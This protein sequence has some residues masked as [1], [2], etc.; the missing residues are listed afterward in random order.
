MEDT[1]ET[2]RYRA[3]TD[4]ERQ[5][6]FAAD[7]DLKARDGWVPVSQATE[8][9][10]GK[11]GLELVVTYERPIASGAGD[12]PAVPLAAGTSPV[13]SS[14]SR[15][16]RLDSVP[17]G[18]PTALVS[19]E[20]SPSPRFAQLASDGPAAPSGEHSR[21]RAG[22]RG[23]IRAVLGPSR[24]E[25][26][27]QL[28][29]QIGAK[30]EPGGFRRSG[31]VVATYAG[32]EITL[33]TY[34]VSSGRSSTTYTRLRAPYVSEDGFRFNVYT[35]TAFSS[36]GLFLEGAKD[37]VIDDPLFDQQFVITTSSETKIR[38][39]L[40]EP[41]IRLALESERDVH[42]ETHAVGDW[43]KP[44]RPGEL[45][46]LY[47]QT[48][49]VV[50]DLNRLKRLFWLFGA[51][52]DALRQMGSASTTSASE[53]GIGAD[54][55]S[56][57]SVAQSVSSPWGGPPIVD[58]LAFTPA[59]T[60][61]VSRWYDPLLARQPRELGWLRW[62]RRS[63]IPGSLLGFLVVSLVSAPAAPPLPSQYL[64]LAL[65]S[66]FEGAVAVGLAWYLARWR[67][68][69]R[70]IRAVGIS[71][72]GLFVGGVVIVAINYLLGKPPS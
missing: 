17:V 66:V 10:I 49:G 26:W 8:Y 29:Q 50:E 58:S 57:S 9:P 31:K 22:L 18:S 15:S 34:A 36:M 64:A 62:L 39:L 56:T 53:R 72:L 35:K 4:P 14:A 27:G 5:Q 61:P 44:N 46:E 41:H 13:P 51:V 40:G 60:G 19:T 7:A 43:H 3:E 52:L 16:P 25:V 63:L 21:S 2:V 59:Y 47:F 28:S 11:P 70:W 38:Q 45:D 69:P 55:S 32:L 65:A 6:A 24:N 68:V 12:D 67:R 20:S 33:D 48:R 1:R 30:F 71:I 42:F 54:R 23:L 37:V